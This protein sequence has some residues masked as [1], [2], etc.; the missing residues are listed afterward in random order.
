MGCMGL[1]SRESCLQSTLGET[2]LGGGLTNNETLNELAV[3]F[4]H[5][6]EQLRLGMTNR[7][8]TINNSSNG[9]RCVLES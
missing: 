2:S 5:G 9:T 7:Q 4:R 1:P 3:F 6:V 8:G